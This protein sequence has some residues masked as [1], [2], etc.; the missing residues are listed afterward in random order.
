MPI[1][2]VHMAMPLQ[3]I[4]KLENMSTFGTLDSSST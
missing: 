1:F 4:A 3:K 2:M